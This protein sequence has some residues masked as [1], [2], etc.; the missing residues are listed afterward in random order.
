MAA[1]L[2]HYALL[3]VSHFA[4]ESEITK[5]YRR[6]A[7]QFHPDKNIHDQSKAEADFKQLAEAYEVLKDPQ[8]R[9]T[10]DLSLAPQVGTSRP[11]VTPVYASDIPQ[12][13]TDFDCGTRCGH[14]T[15]PHFNTASHWQDIPSCNSAQ[16]Q[17][18]AA[19]TSAAPEWT[20]LKSNHFSSAASRGAANFFEPRSTTQRRFSNLASR[21]GNRREEDE[22]FFVSLSALSADISSAG[23]KPRHGE[24][25][26]AFFVSLGGY[27]AST[28]AGSTPG[29][30]RSPS[31][32]RNM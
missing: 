30:S 13:K 14:R 23:R 26:S 29:P 10:F 4:T 25:E 12:R 24:L 11:S 19:N 8:S 9:Q 27:S 20:G 31:P 15:A 1:I 2:D 7:L 18:D 6:K 32:F 5:A 22:A 16:S 28:S 3:E 21:L 17:G